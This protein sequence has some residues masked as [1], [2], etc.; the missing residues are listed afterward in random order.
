MA[1]QA[2]VGIIMGSVSDWETMKRAAD[3]L[4]EL[5]YGANEIEAIFTRG[6]VRRPSESAPAK[7]A[8]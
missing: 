7:A 5:G 1:R 8:D 2:K 4:G 3:I 6:G